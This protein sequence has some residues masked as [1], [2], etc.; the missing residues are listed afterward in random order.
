MKALAKRRP[1]QGFT[2][3][4]TVRSSGRD[5]QSLPAPMS[6]TARRPAKAPMPSR[7]SG[8]PGAA[9]SAKMETGRLRCT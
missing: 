3:Y 7:A 4:P 2:L 1:D 9:V 6:I 8:T 5:A